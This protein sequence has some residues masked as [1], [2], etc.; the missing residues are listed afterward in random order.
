MER[1]ARGRVSPDGP[2]TGETMRDFTKRAGLVVA[3]TALVLG[4]L[5]ACGSDDDGGGSSAPDNAS[6][7]DFCQAFNGLYSKVMAGADSTDAKSTIAALKEWA[8]DMKKVGTPDEMPDDARKGFEVFV[9]QASQI[10]DDASLADLNDLGKDLPQEDQDAGDA[11]GDWAT[12]NCP[13]P[14]DL[15]SLDSVPSE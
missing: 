9:E 8:G 2:R 11:F 10:D 15:P 4:G 5:S 7:D 12:K 3:S 13:A 6:K 1:L 14:T